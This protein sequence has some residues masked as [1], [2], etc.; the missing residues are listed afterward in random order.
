MPA[1]SAAVLSDADLAAV[2]VYLAS[3]PPP[4]AVADIPLLAP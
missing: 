2:R 3:L 4:R 1:F